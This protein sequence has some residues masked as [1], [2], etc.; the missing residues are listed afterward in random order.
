M[1]RHQTYLR[2]FKNPNFPEKITLQIQRVR[3]KN[4]ECRRTHAILPSV[5]VPYSQI[6]MIDTI[7][8]IVEDS[9]EDDERILDENPHLNQ[10][11]LYLVRQK[12]KMLWAERVASIV[13]AMGTRH[14]FQKC[15]DT[16]KM[17]FMQSPQTICG[18]YSC[19]YTIQ[20]AFSFA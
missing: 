16:F 1:I 3:C 11:D 2:K 20:S 18:S 8:I 12:Y 7:T 10:S 13:D 19:D 14:F 4:K 5:I 15:I 6:P 9:R 17:Q